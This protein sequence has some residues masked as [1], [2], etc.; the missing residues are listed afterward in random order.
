M[1]TPQESLALKQKFGLSLEAS[2]NFKILA[3]ALAL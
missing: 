1:L 3:Q 2:S